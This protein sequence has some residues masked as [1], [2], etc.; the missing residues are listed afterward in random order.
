MPTSKYAVFTF[1]NIPS[2]SDPKHT[3]ITEKTPIQTNLRAVLLTVGAVAVAVW[4]AS[5]WMGGVTAKLDTHGAAIV[6]IDG[7][8][9][10]L[11]DHQEKNF[12]RLY[13]AVEGRR[14]V[15]YPAAASASAPAARPEIP[16]N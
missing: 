16:A 3:D 2:M 9:K 11:K 13:A 12:E 10:E 7:Q 14:S 8:L 15:A 1:A 6:A 4:W 5:Q